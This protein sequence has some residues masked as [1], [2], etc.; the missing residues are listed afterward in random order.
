MVFIPRIQEAAS[1]CTDQTFNRSTDK[2]ML[3]LENNPLL[4]TGCQQIMIANLNLI[5]SNCAA[6]LFCCHTA[7]QFFVV[8]SDRR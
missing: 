6:A 2:G 8:V 5:T 7:V 4:R 3:G 1:G